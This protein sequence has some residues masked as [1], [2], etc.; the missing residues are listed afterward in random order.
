M[1]ERLGTVYILDMLQKHLS[2]LF[3]EEIPTLVYSSENH[4]CLRSGDPVGSVEVA[5]IL[6]IYPFKKKRNSL[7]KT[8]YFM[9][10]WAI[11]RLVDESDLSVGVYGYGPAEHGE[12]ASLQEALE[13]AARLI[14]AQRVEESFDHAAWEE[15]LDR[16]HP[17]A[18]DRLKSRDPSEL[19]Y[20]KARRRRSV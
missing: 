11:D 3:S 19:E 6:T 13:E 8:E 20:I 17:G 1:S 18:T 7:S 2:P 15:D 9:T 16:R 5:G 10:H 14:A 12:Y 4:D